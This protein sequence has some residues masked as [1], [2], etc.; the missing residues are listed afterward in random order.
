MGKIAQVSTKYIIHA[1][2]RAE[3]LVDKPDI[4]GAVFGQTEG[5]LGK[6]MELREL[7]KSGRI[8][9]IDVDTSDKNGKTTARIQ[10]PSS[11]DKTKTAIIAAAI[12][13]I[14]RIGPCNGKIDLD[15]I[16]DVRIE[17]R[18][19]IQERAKEILS[20]FIKE[21]D[22]TSELTREV[23]T[24][25]KEAEIVSY[26]PD[27]LPAGPDASSSDE[28]IIVEGRA[29]VLALLRAGVN[30]AISVNGTSIPQTVIN[31]MKTK[32][33]NV[34][35]VD[36]DRGGDLIIKSLKQVGR[37]DFVAKA[38]D[39][40]EIEELTDKEILMT[41]RAREPVVETPAYEKQAFNQEH[42]QSFH[43][44][45][46][47]DKEFFNKALTEVEG[48]G[49]ARL[50][51]SDLSGIGE[52]PIGSI[53]SVKGVSG[54]FAI[55]ADAPVNNSL[56]Y[57]AEDNSAEFLVGTKLE[58]RKRSRVKILTKRTL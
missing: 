34:A 43:A 20:K 53:R 33:V 32:K 57:F 3:G 28:L 9:R 41:L 26:G 18:D 23:S 58:T 55:V 10:I 47:K 38:P 24:S 49:I 52:V 46:F 17:K 51:N 25:V 21:G 35:C 12:E 54:V 4:I 2:L 42:K 7:Q 19:Y 6:D 14:E 15:K 27:A 48:K 40:K 39:G 16:E 30:N 36:G 31:L 50:Y 5:L 11:L 1:T 22:D 37:L 8:G 13:T 56:L 45:R 29:D 44:P